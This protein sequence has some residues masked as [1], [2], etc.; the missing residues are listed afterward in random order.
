M[1]IDNRA[2]RKFPAMIVIIGLLWS[3]TASAQDEPTTD[4]F[5]AK[6]GNGFVSNTAR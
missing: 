5:V 6:L 4:R 3:L 1:A 2:L